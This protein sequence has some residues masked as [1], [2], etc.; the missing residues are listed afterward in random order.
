MR[1]SGDK[2]KDKAKVTD[3]VCNIFF[4]VKVFKAVVQLSEEEPVKIDRWNGS[5]VKHALDDAAKNVTTTINFVV[6]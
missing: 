6:Q 4:W 1:R 2:G 3:K 5:A